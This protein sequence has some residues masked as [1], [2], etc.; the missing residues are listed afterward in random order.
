MFRSLLALVTV[1]T[2]AQLNALNM[3]TYIFGAVVGLV[4]LAIA[5]V[6]ANRIKFQGGQNP[7]DPGR[8][9]LWF[10]MLLAYTFVGFFLYNKFWVAQSVAPNLQSKFMT[11]SLIGC[12]I[13]VG[14]YLI[15]GFIWSKAM[16]RSKVGNWFN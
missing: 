13:A 16:S 5:A 3:Q 12:G 11:A 1:K 15:V 2:P 7:K 4:M 9:R 8:R 6:V 10:W 14:V